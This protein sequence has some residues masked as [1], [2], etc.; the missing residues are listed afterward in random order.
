MRCARLLAMLPL[1]SLLLST[2]THAAEWE[3]LP[4][5][6][7]PNGG[8]LAGVQEN[9][10]VIV[11]GTHWEGGFKNWLKEVHVF[12][13]ATRKWTTLEGAADAPLA[14]GL[15]VQAR[16][17]QREGVP[18]FGFLG[19]TDGT[20]AVKAV[21]TVRNGKVQL[22]PM[23]N[24]PA[25]LVL[26]AGGVFE[27]QQLVVIAG[28]MDDPGNLAGVRR[29]THLIVR[30]VVK[31]AADYPGKPFAVAASAV[32]GDELLVFGGMNHDATTQMPV[33]TDAAYAYSPAKDAW[34]PLKPLVRPNRGLSAVVLNE[35]HVYIAGGYTDDFTADAVVYD[36]KNDTY[37]S[38]PPLPL[39]AMVK[40]IRCGDF[41]YCL[42]GED[43]KQSR[44][45]KCFRISV[46]Q[47]LMPSR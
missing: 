17:P 2:A 34:R 1:T 36:V 28:G 20:Q 25:G 44:T 9:K 42:G 18:H 19:G 23:P 8:C 35:Q 43:K 16:T 26:M 10:I 14:Y 12:D 31:R 6:P 32:V 15:E 47:L 33:N 3:A 29:E 7:A 38:A 40:L 41:I 39:A 21:G 45:D 46:G 24:L 4:P 5:L 30:D 11:G 27:D 37:T 22:A 13:T